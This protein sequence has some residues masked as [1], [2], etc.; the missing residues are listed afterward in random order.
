MDEGS[1]GVHEVELVVEPG[2]GLG[3][4]GG[5]GEHADSTLNLRQV[6][7][8][9]GGRRLVVNTDLQ[10][11]KNQWFKLWLGGRK[12]RRNHNISYSGILYSIYP[13]VANH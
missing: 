4:G 13:T 10:H 5:V 3:D 6:T 7:A 1:L 8:R 2:P 9:D 12:L 11:T